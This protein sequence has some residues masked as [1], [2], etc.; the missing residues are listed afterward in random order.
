MGTV[1]CIN[2]NK[3]ID[4]DLHELLFIG[5]AEV[6]GTTDWKYFQKSYRPIPGSAKMKI[7]CALC[8]AKGKAWFDDVKVVIYNRY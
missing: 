5:T 7:T 2:C 6:T 8:N 3:E 1:K 4:E